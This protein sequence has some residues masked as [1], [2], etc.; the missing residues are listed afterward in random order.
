MNLRA[1]QLDDSNLTKLQSLEK[2][3]GG[4]IV[5]WEHEIKPASLNEDQ[6]KELQNLEKEIDAVLVAYNV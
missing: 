3:L 5:A 6:V 4:V 2:K 1:K